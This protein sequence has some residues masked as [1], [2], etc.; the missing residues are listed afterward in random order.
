MWRSFLR[1]F[2]PLLVAGL[3]FIQAARAQREIPEPGPLNQP[4]QPTQPT[5]PPPQTEEPK[6]HDNTERTPGVQYLF[7]FVSFLIVM[8]IVCKPSRKG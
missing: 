3:F 6:K 7:A 5:Q 4:N 2:S 1:W 8:L